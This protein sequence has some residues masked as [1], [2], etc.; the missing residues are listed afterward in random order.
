MVGAEL[1]KPQ[2]AIEMIEL[3]LKKSKSRFMQLELNSSDQNFLGYQDFCRII[4]LLSSFG[5]RLVNQI[6]A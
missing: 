3:R 5:S 2:S 1:V 6:N 4:I